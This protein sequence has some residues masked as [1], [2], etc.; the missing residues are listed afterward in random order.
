[1]W[2][3]SKKCRHTHVI[4]VGVRMH[5]ATCSSTRV[6]KRALMFAK[7][8]LLT[9][10]WLTSLYTYSSHKVKSYVLYEES[11]LRKLG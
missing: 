3:A 10:S 6:D 7:W 1:M 2:A 4:H 9:I 11:I 8:M 5:A